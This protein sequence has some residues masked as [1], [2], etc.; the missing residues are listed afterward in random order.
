MVL[1]P[2]QAVVLLR[3]KQDDLGTHSSAPTYVSTLYQQDGTNFLVSQKMLK[4]YL[5]LS[6]LAQDGSMGLASIGQA[7]Q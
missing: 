7:W 5:S 2:N 3:L 6:N 1:R 4:G